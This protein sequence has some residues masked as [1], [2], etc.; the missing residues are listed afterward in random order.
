MIEVCDGPGV[1]GRALAIGDLVVELV[2]AVL[3]ATGDHVPQA[4][5]TLNAEGLTARTSQRLAA[6]VSTF[7]VPRA[8]I[9]LITP[10]TTHDRKRLY[11]NVTPL[12]LAS[13]AQFVTAVTTYATKVGLAKLGNRQQDSDG[14]Q[15]EDAKVRN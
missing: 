8:G 10:T 14:G 2:I 1:G 7:D 9:Y 15:N 5:H 3:A 11:R 6:N 12:S 4:S 13:T